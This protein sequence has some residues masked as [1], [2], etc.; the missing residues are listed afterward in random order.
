MAVDPYVQ[1]I[2][3]GAPTSGKSRFASG[4]VQMHGV[5]H[6]GVDALIEAFEDVCPELGIT[7]RAFGTSAHEEVCGRFGPFAARVAEGL[8][9]TSFVLEGFRLPIEFMAASCPW[10]KAIVFGFPHATPAEKVQACRLYDTDN[11]TN[12]MTDG[13]LGRWFGFFIEQSVRDAKACSRLGIPF[14]DTSTDYEG[15]LG[16]ALIDA[17]SLRS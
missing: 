4:L 7:H 2:V 3:M 10:T 6:V 9:T 5:E 1:Y 8:R 11:W 17:A 16:R 13:E 14:Y 12:E 15:T